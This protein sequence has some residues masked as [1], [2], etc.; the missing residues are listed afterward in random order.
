MLA[1]DRPHCMHALLACCGAEIP[2]HDQRVRQLASFHYMRAVEGLRKGLNNENIR[3]QWMV[4]MLT[5]MML[6]IYEVR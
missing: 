6:C 2:T 1:L 4:T 3:S 5:V